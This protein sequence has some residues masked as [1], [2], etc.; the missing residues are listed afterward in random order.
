VHVLAAGA[1]GYGNFGDDCYVDIL[2][3]R[4][5]GYQLDILSRID[6]AELK[7]HSYDASMVAGGGVLYQSLSENGPESLKHYL[8]Y[9]AIAQWL[10]K[11]SFMIGVGVQG[12]IQTQSV[13]PFLSV[14]EGMN[15][16][17]VRDN[18]SARLLR[19]AGVTSPVLECADLLYSKA[20]YPKHRVR[21]TPG[22]PV[23]GVVASQPGEGILHPHFDGFDDRI[24]QA[25]R[26]LEKD[27]RLHF[28]SFDDRSDPWLAQSW[29]GNHMYS[30]FDPTRPDAVNEFIM[31]F[32]NVDAFVTTRYHGVILSVMTGTPFLAI[33]A[34]AEKVQRECDAIRHPYF[35]SYD[36][37]VN[38][39]ALSALE[40]WS[41][42]RELRELM[43]R[44]GMQRRR[45]ALR[46]F[47]LLFAENSNR[48]SSGTQM[49]SRMVEATRKSSSPRTLVIWAAGS[50]CWS[51]AGGLFAQL[52]D[53]DCLLPPRSPLR[54]TSI[55]QRI[56]LPEP[57]IFNW[58]AFPNEL[59]DRL[60]M[61]YDN[62][63]VCHAAADRKAAD[64]VDI[65]S[66]SGHCI[67][68]FDVWI[69]AIRHDPILKTQGVPA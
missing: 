48:A 21:R 5:A 4:L 33:G 39:I 55:G 27:F 6:E 58:V 62:V 1:Y 10:G 2:Q 20:I 28:F 64:L 24:Q 30:S 7:L 15:L 43:R 25:L 41:E 42:R 26:I 34:P 57:G 8:R 45:L 61:N 65:A 22:K 66:Q 14:L 35:L 12:P 18:F 23:L 19:G 68:E 69:H 13:T 52:R 36:S 9:P 29:T 11:K 46:N 44:E 53:F 31:A 49:I 17:T 63:I 16:R 50:E 38:R 3:S 40:V 37:S 51:E 59:K 32:E 54:H 60:G 47:E 67:W 56:L